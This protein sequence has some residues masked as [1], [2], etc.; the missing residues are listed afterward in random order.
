MIK[1]A[2]FVLIIFGF[3]YSIFISLFVG[4]YIG[5]VL[6]LITIGF[7]ATIYCIDKRI[8]RKIIF[9][10]WIAI[11]SFSVLILLVGF[12]FNMISMLKI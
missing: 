9:Y 7:A 12:V 3:V 2:L 1:L 10:V 8:D 11:I 5:V 6:I 4:L